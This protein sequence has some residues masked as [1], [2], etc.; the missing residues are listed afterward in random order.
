MAETATKKPETVKSEEKKQEEKKP[1]TKTEAAKESAKKEET[2]AEKKETKPAAA[3]KEA[4]KDSTTP[5]NKQKDADPA[6]P[7]EKI[8]ES[9][10]EDTD[11][12]SSSTTAETEEG[13]PVSETPK[14]AEKSGE[15]KEEKTMFQLV[16]PRRIAM[17]MHPT[18]NAACRMIE[19]T[20][21]CKSDRDINGW[22]TVYTGVPEIGKVTGFIRKESLGWR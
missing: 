7:A 1:A 2:K 13:K 5:V 15:V 17:Y 14:A 12:E 11:L 3:K 22:L 18:Y 6:K 16:L 19:G 8:D 9:V 21:I 10:N 20:V 4:K